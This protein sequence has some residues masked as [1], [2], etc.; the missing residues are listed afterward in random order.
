MT[1]H[2]FLS[3]FSLNNDIEWKSNLTKI[4]RFFGLSFLLLLLPLVSNAQSFDNEST[5]LV[6]NNQQSHLLIGN[7][8]EILNVS[9]MNL[10]AS[11]NQNMETEI[12][13]AYDA[14]VTVTFDEMPILG[15][16]QI[17]GGTDYQF[18]FEED[19]EGQTSFSF[20]LALPANGEELELIV[21]YIGAETS[22]FVYQTS[23]TT[24]RNDF[25]NVAVTPY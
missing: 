15:T 10:G 16:L 21:T 17:S 2:T 8:P 9:M 22:R 20:K 19:N 7:A 18:D 4:E 14:L 3:N 24:S 11:Y 5:A 25:R 12:M 6:S 13:D 1:S 23:G